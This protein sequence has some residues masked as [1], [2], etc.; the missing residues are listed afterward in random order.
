MVAH[1]HYLE[2]LVRQDENQVSLAE[3]TS[4]LEETAAAT[5]GPSQANSRNQH[6]PDTS[7]LLS[8]LSGSTGEE[9]AETLRK[10]MEDKFIHPL[11]DKLKLAAVEVAEL[12]EMKKTKIKVELIKGE[13][14]PSASF[15]VDPSTFWSE[16]NV[17]RLTP[18]QKDSLLLLHLAL[19]MKKRLVRKSSRTRLF[20]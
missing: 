20:K 8:L 17:N 1:S 10:K 13:N 14:T 18:C 6:D 12:E 7:Q 3:L 2:Q 19:G 11:N 16:E 9:N 4:L 15:T 5:P